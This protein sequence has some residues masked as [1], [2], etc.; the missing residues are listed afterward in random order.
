MPGAS[1]IG[2][3]S[4][5]DVAAFDALMAMGE[6]HPRTRSTFVSALV[7]AEPPDVGRLRR[8]L[9]H[10]SRRVE[11]LRQRMVFP[12][13]DITAPRWVVDPDFDLD[14]HFRRTSLPAPGGHDELL[15]FIEPLL[16]SPLDRSR[17]LWET[18]LVE[19]LEG[20][21]A[22]VVSRYSHALFDGIGGLLALGRLF[23]QEPDPPQRPMPLEPVPEDLTPTDLV[24]AALPRLPLAWA[25]DLQRGLRVAGR[26]GLAAARH[27]QRAAGSAAT[28]GRAVRGL[29]GPPS[30]VAPSPLLRR[31]SP[32]RRVFT[33]TVDLAELKAA[34]RSAGATVND[35][36]LAS[37][38]AGMAAYHDALGAPIEAFPL[39]FPISL[40]TKGDDEASNRWTGARIPAPANIADPI[41]RMAALHALADEARRTVG[42]D[43]LGRVTPLVTRLPRW[44]IGELSATVAS[45]DIQASNVPGWT[46]AVYLAGARV[47]ASYPFGPLPGVAAMITL[48]SVDGVCYVGVNYDP[49]AFADG[50]LFAACLRRG[51][52]D[53]VAVGRND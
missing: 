25:G 13:I 45:T 39:A 28:W 35:A 4:S 2:P 34:G 15:A 44:A 8:R 19:G 43:V 22:A 52:D 23:D 9:D 26:T 21:R 38:A 7:L 31:R 27:P 41:Q 40:R 50:E 17:P 29:L 10:T 51:F 37:V 3:T 49:A 32:A 6:D 12:A 18:H 53:V 14:Y 33:L 11:R 42:V 16:M 47:V 48:L 24:R 1:L 5:H 36:Y 20:G 30:G 46:G